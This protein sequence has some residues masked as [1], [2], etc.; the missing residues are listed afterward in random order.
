VSPGTD[1]TGECLA[2]VFV[3]KLG[4]AITIRPELDV[5]RRRERCLLDFGARTA[6]DQE[7]MGSTFRCQYCTHA[8]R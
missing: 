6:L 7:E 8:V 5:S 2:V 3:L 1:V 4:T